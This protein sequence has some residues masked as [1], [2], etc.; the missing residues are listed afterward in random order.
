MSKVTTTWKDVKDYIKDHELSREQRIDLLNYF[1]KQINAFSFDDVIKILPTGAILANG[2][3]LSL[4]QREAFLQGCKAIIGNYAFQTITDQIMFQSMKVGMHDATEM[5]HVFFS[6]V[7]LYYA[8][9]YKQY[10]IKL[11]QLA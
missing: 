7:A 3:V 8:D 6:K 2:K 4:E 9:L 1:N 5:D 11:D 10:L